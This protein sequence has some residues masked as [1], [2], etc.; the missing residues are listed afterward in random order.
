MRSKDYEITRQGIQMQMNLSKYRLPF[1]G[2]KFSPVKS[3]LG[4]VL[5][6]C[7]WENLARLPFPESVLGFNVSLATVFLF[8]FL[9]IRSCLSMLC[10]WKYPSQKL[11]FLQNNWVAETHKAV[12]QQHAATPCGCFFG[13]HRHNLAWDS[14]QIVDLRVSQNSEPTFN[15]CYRCGLDKLLSLLLS[16]FDVLWGT[17]GRM[18]HMGPDL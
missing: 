9:K 8:L 7:I 11:H 4:R 15:T 17:K 16:L 12:C 1:S 2:E 14:E 5:C 18:P 3:V 6:Q 13:R 10:L